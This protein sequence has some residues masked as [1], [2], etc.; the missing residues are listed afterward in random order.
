MGREVVV[1]VTSGKL[2]WTV[3]TDLLRR[4]D[5]NR[6]KRVLVKIMGNERAF[7]N[8]SAVQFFW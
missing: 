7:P 6:K 5:G 3:G 1:A 2:D 4:I 8:P